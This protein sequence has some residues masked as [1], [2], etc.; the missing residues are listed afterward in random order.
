LDTFTT[1]ID[2][3]MR[4][5][6]LFEKHHVGVA[7]SGIAGRKDIEKILE[8]GIH[9]FLIGESLVRASDPRAFL[10]SLIQQ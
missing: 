10:K 9:N 5:A 2:T 3:S 8:A 7:E 1:D 4:L 6:S